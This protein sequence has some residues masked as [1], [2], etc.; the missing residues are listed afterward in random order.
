V[1]D[2]AHR[3]RDSNSPVHQ[4]ASR[5]FLIAKIDVFKGVEIDQKRN[6]VPSLYKARR[7]QVTRNI[8]NCYVMWECD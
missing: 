7:D 5:S 6:D 3:Q 2:Q 8:P 1:E 4:T